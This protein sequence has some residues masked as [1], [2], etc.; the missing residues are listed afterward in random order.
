MVARVLGLCGVRGAPSIGQHSP[1]ARTDLLHGGQDITAHLSY[2][3]L[4]RY[5]RDR[6][7]LE[8]PIRWF[9]ALVADN[10]SVPHVRSRTV[11]TALRTST[12]RH[13]A[14]EQRLLAIQNMPLLHAQSLLSDLIST[15]RGGV[16][17]GRVWDLYRSWDHPD[18][19][20]Q[21]RHRRTVLAELY[22]SDLDDTSSADSLDGTATPADP[23]LTPAP[24]N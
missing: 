16:D 6:D 3:Y 22:Q 2:P 14:V 21:R 12:L 8:Q 24:T 1:A 20:R 11:G 5:W 19:D 15:C 4:A 23:D 9:A 7:Y 18:P 10:R 17:W 13:Q